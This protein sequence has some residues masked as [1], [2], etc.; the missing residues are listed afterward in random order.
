MAVAIEPSQLLLWTFSEVEQALQ[1]G[2]T[3]RCHLLELY[4]PVGGIDATVDDVR[5]VDEEDARITGEFNVLTI[6][7]WH[8]PTTVWAIR[9]AK[10]AKSTI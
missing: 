3:V 1:A 6:Y 5:D 8:R 10:E 2:W 9:P 7:G 4:M